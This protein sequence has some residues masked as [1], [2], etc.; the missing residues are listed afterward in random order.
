MRDASD[1]QKEGDSCDGPLQSKKKQICRGG[2]R[3]WTLQR[4]PRQEFK[5]NAV[6]GKRR[7]KYEV[8]GRK[9]GNGGERPVCSG[10]R[11]APRWR[12]DKF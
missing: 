11:F 9:P 1:E 12:E 3:I 7:E 8:R 4:A 2:L 6:G 10:W 5:K